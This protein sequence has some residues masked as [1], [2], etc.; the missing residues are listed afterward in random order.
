MKPKKWLT[1]LISLCVLFTM[2]SCKGKE[3]VHVAQRT[4]IVYIAARN[5]LG[6]NGFDTKDIA[7]IELAVS[8]GALP[9]N[10]NLL[11]YHASGTNDGVLYRITPKGKEIIERYNGD[12][13]VNADHLAHVIDKAQQVAP[14]I[15]YGLVLWSHAMGWTQNHASRSAQTCPIPNKTTWGDENGRTMD[16]TE[17]ASAL[18]G[19]D[20][21]FIYFDCCY[22]A[23][24]EALYELRNCAQFIVA[25][26]AELPANGMPY[27]LTLPF[28]MNGNLTE[29]A[30][31]TF[32][33]Y[34]SQQGDDRTCTISVI[35]TA[36]LKPLAQVCAAIAR[37]SNLNTP[38][39]YLPQKFMTERTCYFF[40]L[41]QYYNALAQQCS[42]PGLADQLH[43][44]LT[45]AVEFQAA[46]P[47]IWNVLP[48]TSHCGLTTYI[49]STA[50]NPKN[51]N[52]LQWYEKVV[53]PALN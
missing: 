51:Y 16:I 42:T 45:K 23:S 20:L 37:E 24:V 48:V 35:N 38:Q 31:I 1:I 22:M 26:A 15:S 18:N 17:L 30:K 44:A 36:G 29:A 47:Y 14:A 34:D 32:N 21:E 3:P 27:H 43:A 25:C 6:Q 50:N 49:T 41:Q 28:L 13:S 10:T 11:I 7:E 8:Q 40:D 5:S 9:P 46:T 53:A 39:G 2:P 33:H 52:T 12:N 4:V 19:K